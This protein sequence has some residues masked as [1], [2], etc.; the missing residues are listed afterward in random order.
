M[1]SL[2]KTLSDMRQKHQ[3][4]WAHPLEIAANIPDSEQN[5]VL[6]HSSY[7]A[8]YTGQRSILTLAKQQEICA[9]NFDMFAGVLSADRER[10]TNSWFGYLG[11]DLKNCLE[12]LRKDKKFYIS[13]PALYMA[14]YGLVL[15]FDNKNKQ[16]TAWTADESLLKQIPATCPA[17]AN[18]TQP[19]E[20]EQINSNMDKAEYLQKVAEI[21]DMILRGDLLQANLTR[22]FYGNF[23]NKP[24][25]FDIYRKL[26]D[27]SPSPYSAFIRYGDSYIIS[28]S[29][30]RFLTIDENGKAES[31]P[32]KGSIKRSLDKNEDEKLKTALENSEKDRAENLMIVD[33]MRN[34]LSRSCV[35]GSIKVESLFD[36][37]S[38]A[39]V[40]HMSSTISGQKNP[41]KTTLELVKGC[42]PP[43]SMTGAPKIKAMQVCSEMEK[44]QRGVYSGAIGWFGGDGSADLSVVIRTLIIQSNKFEFQVG[45][46]ITADSEPEK[47][48]EETLVKATAIARAL[49]IPLEK[50]GF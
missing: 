36:V 37:T 31:R 34:D 3:L 40:H 39:T 6:L 9:D 47:E 4:D 43:G 13:L 48:W 24:N 12:K 32:I 18:T 10:F 7:D 11:Y 45:G 2:K 35:P 21:K 46:A 1:L 17:P 19:P 29:P 16:L 38:Y 50:L 28:S 44:L 22:K 20:I 8:G 27:I 14:Q 33:L 42:F 5:W 41:N 30:E 15:D 49:G 25:P 26:L 23:N